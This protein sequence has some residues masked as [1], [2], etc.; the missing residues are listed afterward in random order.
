MYNVP[1]VLHYAANS[2]TWVC[3]VPFFVRFTSK[4]QRIWFLSLK[5]YQCV[6][7]EHGAA[8]QI[9]TLVSEDRMRISIFQTSLNLVVKIMGC[10]RSSLKQTSKWLPKLIFKI[11]HT[12]KIKKI[13]YLHIG[14]TYEWNR[15]LLQGNDY[16]S[17]Y[18]Q[19]L[20]WLWVFKKSIHLPFI[21]S[22]SFPFAYLIIYGMSWPQAVIEPIDLQTR[23]TL[24]WLPQ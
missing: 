4:E 15:N 7:T 19:S 20:Q 13:F 10:C 9:Y 1:V 22:Q 18:C 24:V 23:F 14:K 17:I 16:T 8:F 5:H 12:S 11:S 21:N 3:S 6:P 2:Q